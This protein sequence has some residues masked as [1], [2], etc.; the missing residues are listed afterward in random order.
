MPHSNY[1]PQTLPVARTVIPAANFFAYARCNEDSIQTR[2][3]DPDYVKGGY[4]R[5][6]AVLELADVVW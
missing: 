3:I 4:V 6:E 2:N 1:K 5:T